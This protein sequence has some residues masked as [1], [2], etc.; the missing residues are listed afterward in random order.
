MKFKDVLIENEK[1][2]IFTWQWRNS[3][4][5]RTIERKWK[6]NE[7]TGGSYMLYESVKLGE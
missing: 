5:K 2:K 7:E 4:R 3:K 6:A 1:K